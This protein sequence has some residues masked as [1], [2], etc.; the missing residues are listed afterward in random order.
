MIL[1]SLII[2]SINCLV[3][4]RLKCINNHRVIRKTEN[5]HIL[6]LELKICLLQLEVKQ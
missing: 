5:I 1:C 2:L 6:K 3:S 4:N